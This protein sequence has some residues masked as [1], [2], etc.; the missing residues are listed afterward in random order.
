[1]SSSVVGHETIATSAMPA[2][3]IASSAWK[4]I[5][6][7]ATGTSDAATLGSNGV[8]LTV[9]VAEARMTPLATISFNQRLVGRVARA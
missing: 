8:R 3:R 5:G 9:S 2:S 1:M 6:W 4:R 7:L